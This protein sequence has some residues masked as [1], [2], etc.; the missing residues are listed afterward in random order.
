[1]A[2]ILYGTVLLLYSVTCM[3][4]ATPHHHLQCPSTSI[5][6]GGADQLG[7]ELNNGSDTQRECA[8]LLLVGVLKQHLGVLFKILAHKPC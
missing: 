5:S 8:V 6:D 3:G 2:I 4:N 7:L 1:M